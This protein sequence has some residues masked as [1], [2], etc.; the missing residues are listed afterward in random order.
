[1][2]IL[3]DFQCDSGHLTEEFV[4]SVCT[5]VPCSVCQKPATRVYLR[6][7]HLDWSGMAQGSSAGPEFVERFERVHREETAR[8]EKILREHGDY[9][10]GY[11]A[12]PSI[13]T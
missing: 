12:P 6:A 9:G 2:A 8:Q 4:S 7:P 11:A 1:M 3:H 10:P 5:Q 13:G